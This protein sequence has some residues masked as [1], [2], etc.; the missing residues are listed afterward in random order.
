MVSCSSSGPARSTERHTR[1]SR[2][3]K[4]R[5]ILTHA[6]GSWRRLR[7]A[8][9]LEAAAL[10]T[11]LL[12]VWLVVWLWPDGSQALAAYTRH[13]PAWVLIDSDMK[14]ADGLAVAGQIS[15]AFPAAR[16]L[17][18]T[19]YEDADLRQAAQAAGAC[20]YVLKEN[21][22]V[23]SELIGNTQTTANPT[24]FYTG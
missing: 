1:T 20:G 16:I 6:R 4:V 18:I 10:L 11:G 17:I 19:G 23:V 7:P 9:A 13:R 15:A 8:R 21:L 3:C 5:A 12:G 24:Q 2:L 14:T 22:T